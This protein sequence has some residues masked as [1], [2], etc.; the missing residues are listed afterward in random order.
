MLVL[1]Q[2][3]PSVFDSLFAISRYITLQ[4]G[5]LSAFFP[6]FFQ[7]LSWVII[8]EMDGAG[9]GAEGILLRFE[10]SVN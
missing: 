8:R 6:H 10:N 2:V 1:H 7:P 4:S 3:E 9:L 5:H